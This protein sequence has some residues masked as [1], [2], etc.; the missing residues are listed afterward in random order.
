MDTRV[1]ITGGDSWWGFYAAQGFLKGPKV[2]DQKDGCQ[3]CNIVSATSQT[4][5]SV[6]VLVSNENSTFAV[7]LK[8][9]GM[10]ISTLYTHANRWHCSQ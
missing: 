3:E 4:T 5:Y 8:K 7:R 9:L 10:S 6:T 1:L 2:E